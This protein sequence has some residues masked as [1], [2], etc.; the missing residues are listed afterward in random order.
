MGT[1]LADIMKAEII[2]LN[3]LKDRVIAFDAF[4]TVYA[5]LSSIRQPDGTPLMDRKGRVTSHLSGLF[6][7]NLNLLE[8]GVRP[9]YVFDGKPPELKAAE[10]DRRKEIRD[11][12]YEE[13]L[14]AKEEGRI[15]DAR[16]AAQ[17][18]S[19]L[20]TSMIEESKNLLAAL[21]IPVIQA[22][23]EGEALAAQMTRA[24]IAWASAS[25]DNDSFLYNC[26]RLVRN[27]TIS[28]RRRASRSGSYKAVHPELVDL[29]MNLR[30]LGITREQLIDIAIL[31][32]TDY[33]D[34][35]KGIGPKTALKLIKKHL[36][37][38]GIEAAEDIQYNFPYDEIRNIFLNPPKAD[39]SKPKWHDFD[40]DNLM[41]ILC[42]EHDFSLSRVE[43][44]LQRLQKALEELRDSTEQSSLTD[45]F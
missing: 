11:A 36:D 18:S 43:S 41:R 40:K 35:V 30:L 31:V 8:A 9:V 6:Y 1:K 25:Q 28:G 21:G 23:S 7:R 20:T 32:G 4:N 39:I 12:A 37:I 16:K 38:E 5:F 13:W 15:E 22:P 10:V 19:R 27:L 26:P 33:N 14:V 45:F 2:S 29:D 3:D 44:S 42:N 24:N 17:A 34:G